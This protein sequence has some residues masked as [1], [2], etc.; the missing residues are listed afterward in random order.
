MEKEDSKKDEC[1]PKFDTTL[2]QDRTFDWTD[3]LFATDR[4]TCIF[5]IPLNMGQVI[6]RMMGKIDAANALDPEVIML[7][8]DPTP[9]VS[10]QFIPVVKEVPGLKHV[11]L[12]GKFITKIFEGP[13]QEA[14]NWYTEMFRFAESQGM[15]ASKVYFY[16]TTCPKCAKK[17]G[18]NYVVG[19]ARVG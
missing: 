12:S 18:K 11:K 5:H 8:E 9:W 19:F 1:C 13:Y 3:K 7:T 10:D 4:V 6:T 17:W 16:Y 15:K 14:K 2:W